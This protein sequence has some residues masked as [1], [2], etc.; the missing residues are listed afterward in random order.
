MKKL[1]KANYYSND[2]L[3]VNKGESMAKPYLDNNTLSEAIEVLNELPKD[4]M[5]IL[6]N[7]MSLVMSQSYRGPIPPAS[8]V[9]K[10]KDATP[11]APDRIFKMAEFEQDS[12][13]RQK[14]KEI[15]NNFIL[16][17]LG[18]IYGLLVAFLFGLGSVYLGLNGH[19]WLAGSLGGLTVISLVSVFVLSKLPKNN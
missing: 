16:K 6:T 19:D 18:Q 1:N 2:S 3:Y 9:I 10:Y 14:D 7:G 4:K 13:I 11:D 5:E 15:H 8:E 17:L 12:R